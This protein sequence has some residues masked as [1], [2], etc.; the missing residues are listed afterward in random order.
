MLLKF[1]EWQLPTSKL[2]NVLGKNNNMLKFFIL[3][4]TFL[5]LLSP[6]S[7]GGRVIC[8]NFF[9]F[10]NEF[11]FNNVAKEIIKLYDSKVL[12]YYKYHEGFTWWSIHLSVSQ[13]HSYSRK[14]LLL[15]MPIHSWYVTYNRYL[16]GMGQKHIVI[17]KKKSI[18]LTSIG[19]AGWCQPVQGLLT[20]MHSR[21]VLC[22]YGTNLL[23]Y[24]VMG[25]SKQR[26]GILSHHLAFYSTL[27]FCCILLLLKCGKFFTF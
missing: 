18:M 27:P 13:T 14:V 26:G 16:I 17:K 20:C 22:Q 6:L 2:L 19:G 15:V 1:F 25:L 23:P 4:F 8:C 9:H 11:R 12:D 5:P 3:F 24:H 7:Y 21:I 10:L